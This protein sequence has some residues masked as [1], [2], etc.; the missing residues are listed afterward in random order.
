MYTLL[1]LKWITS[2]DLWCSTWNSAQCY[3]PAWLGGALGRMDTCVCIAE[4]LQRSPETT[5]TLFINYT[6]L[7]RDLMLKNKIKIKKRKEVFLTCTE[8]QKRLACLTPASTVGLGSITQGPSWGAPSGAGQACWGS[9]ERVKEDG[10]GKKKR[11]V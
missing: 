7:Q 5:T 1:R 8:P 2:K 9:M 3:V 6:P 11:W 4:S 10:G